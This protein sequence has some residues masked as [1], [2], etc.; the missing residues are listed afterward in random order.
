MPKQPVM[1]VSAPAKVSGE[2]L[3][4]RQAPVEAPASSQA[5]PATEEKAPPV[6]A[7]TKPKAAPRQGAQAAPVAAIVL[8]ILTMVILSALAT[9]IYLKS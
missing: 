4:V 2:P 8:A 9:A 3:A 7:A 5:S 6:Q 1:D